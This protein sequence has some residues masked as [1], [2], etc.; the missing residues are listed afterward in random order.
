MQKALSADPVQ[1]DEVSQKFVREEAP[2]APQFCRDQWENLA[3]FSLDQAFG[4]IRKGFFRIDPRCRVFD[5][6]SAMVQALY[7]NCEFD[8]KRGV[9]KNEEQCLMSVGSYRS[10]W[11]D[12]LSADVKDPRAMSL[13]L[14]ANKIMAKIWTSMPSPQSHAELLG[15][16]H[17]LIERKPDSLQARKA[18]VAAELGSDETNESYY[19][20]VH[21]AAEAALELAPGE[22]Q[23]TEVL[24]YSEKR[25]GNPQAI[26]DYLQRNPESGLAY[27]YQAWQEHDSGQREAALANL[28]E[29]HRL[30]PGDQRIAQTLNALEAGQRDKLFSMEIGFTFDGL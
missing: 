4:D 24:L 30:A 1:P 13:S 23:V 22:P 11:I 20:S 18:L 3:R 14:L 15:L 10:I 27:Y 12:R 19:E 5:D 21:K 16:I 2:K 17:E 28:R 29:A 8:A 6:K 9:L 25:R 7:Q 26:Q